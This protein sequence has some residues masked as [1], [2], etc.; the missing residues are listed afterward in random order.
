M[1]DKLLEVIAE[2]CCKPFPYSLCGH[3]HNAIQERK[4]TTLQKKENE[5]LRKEKI[6]SEEWDIRMDDHKLA[7]LMQSKGCVKLKELIDRRCE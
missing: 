6:K 3:T 4:H 5:E 2:C 7:E 1:S